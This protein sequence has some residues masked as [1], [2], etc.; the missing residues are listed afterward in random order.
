MGLLMLLLK[1]SDD[2]SIGI[3]FVDGDRESSF[4]VLF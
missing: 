3:S 1:G 2:G 4:W